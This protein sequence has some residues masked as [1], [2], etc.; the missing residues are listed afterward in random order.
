MLNLPALFDEISRNELDKDQ[1]WHQR[2]VLSEECHLV[3]GFH[4][5][6]DR[7]LEEAASKDKGKPSRDWLL[8]LPFPFQM[9][10]STGCCLTGEEEKRCHHFL[11]NNMLM[12]IGVFL[13]WL[14]FLSANNA[15]FIFKFFLPANSIPLVRK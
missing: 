8:N 4:M 12:S 3:F 2:L 5:E 9:D 11:P 10:P 13:F 7:V 1:P 6:I 14:V 15:L